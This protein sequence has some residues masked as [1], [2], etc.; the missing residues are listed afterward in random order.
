M[1]SERCDGGH[2]SLSDSLARPPRRHVTTDHSTVTT[3]ALS[4]LL[5]PTAVADSESR[6]ASPQPGTVT[7]GDCHGV[8][9]ATAVAPAAPRVIRVPETAAAGGPA[10]SLSLSRAASGRAQT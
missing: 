1:S 5:P 10:R 6:V 9:E 7:P 3:I 4:L 2:G 8:T